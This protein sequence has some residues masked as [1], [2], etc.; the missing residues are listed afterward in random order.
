[1]GGVAGL[2]FNGENSLGHQPIALQ[3]FFDSDGRGRIPASPVASPP[4]L[5]KTPYADRL[6]KN[7]AGSGSYTNDFDRLQRPVAFNRG[8]EFPPSPDVPQQVQALM[9]ARYQERIRSYEE[10]R[11][12]VV[13]SQTLQLMQ[14]VFP[15]YRIEGREGEAASLLS[16]RPGYSGDDRLFSDLV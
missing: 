3:G 6:F 1:T 7:L 10:R 13:E 2:A 16:R 12:S 15:H 8:V 14:D 11:K 4:V 9:L 5:S